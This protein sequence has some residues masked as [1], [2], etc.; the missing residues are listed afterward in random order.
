MPTCVQNIG[1]FIECAIVVQT[2]RFSLSF[3]VS[4]K[5]AGEVSLL[6]TTLSHDYLI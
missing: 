3:S 4:R 2:G 1:L 6:S 5:I